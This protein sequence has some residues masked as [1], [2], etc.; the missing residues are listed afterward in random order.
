MIYLV[1]GY[2]V[3]FS[4][5]LRREE[6][7]E[8]RELL[9]KFAERYKPDRIIIVFDGKL[10]VCGDKPSMAVFTKGISADEYIKNYVR[11]SKKPGE[12]VVVTND[13]AVISYVKNFGAKTMSPW[14]FIQ[15]PLRKKGEK[16]LSEMEE[17]KL[18]KELL[19]EW[20]GE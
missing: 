3:I 14:K 16:E 9:Y 10:G 15:G 1:D 5:G 12:I 18:K 17:E 4:A 6:L 19:R 11:N 7:A 8:S 13:R 20:G 2:N